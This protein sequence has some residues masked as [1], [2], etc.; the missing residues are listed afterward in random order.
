MSFLQLYLTVM[1]HGRQGVVEWEM[2]KWLFGTLWLKGAWLNPRIDTPI[3]IHPNHLFQGMILIWLLPL[4]PT[5]W[6]IRPPSPA[7]C[8]HSQENKEIHQQPQ[9]SHTHFLQFIHIITQLSNVLAPEY[10]ISDQLS[11]LFVL[12]NKE[13]LDLQFYIYD[14]HSQ[15][16]TFF[17]SLLLASFPTD[18]IQGDVTLYV[19]WTV[20]RHI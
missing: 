8:L 15:I 17:S 2:A 16:C 1:Q 19:T 9:E 14:V 20:W 5:C 4:F 13:I 12:S 3:P 7:L 11:L 10:C 6:T 18:T